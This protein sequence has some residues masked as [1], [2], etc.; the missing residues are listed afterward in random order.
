MHSGGGGGVT[1]TLGEYTASI[2]FYSED[3]GIIY[4]RN[5]IPTYQSTHCHNAEDNTDFYYCRNLK[6][7]I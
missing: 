3:G 2:F 7:Y 4:L 5:M 1:N 6:F